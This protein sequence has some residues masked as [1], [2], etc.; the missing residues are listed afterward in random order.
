LVIVGFSMDTVEMPA[1]KIMFQELQIRG[2]L[3]CRPVDYPRIVELVRRGK[4]RIEPLVTKRVSLREINVGLDA[5]RH[6]DGLRTIVV[7]SA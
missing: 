2:S 6:G 3:G 1:G 7:P 4:I 5:L